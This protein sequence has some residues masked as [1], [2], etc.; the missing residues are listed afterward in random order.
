LRPSLR[1]QIVPRIGEQA[2]ALSRAALAEPGQQ[3]AQARADLHGLYASQARIEQHP[4]WCR[5][6]AESHG[7]RALGVRVHQH[8]EQTD[9]QMEVVVRMTVLRGAGQVRHV[10]VAVLHE[11]VDAAPLLDERKPLRRRAVQKA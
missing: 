9:Q 11:C 7:E 5:A 10:R 2:P 6:D 8:R 4:V 1:A 3:L